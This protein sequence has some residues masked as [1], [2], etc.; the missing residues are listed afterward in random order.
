MGVIDVLKKLVRFVV[1]VRR[2]FIATAGHQGG[3]PVSTGIWRRGKRAV[4][5]N[6]LKRGNL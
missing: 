1:L 6:H 4:G 2:S 5:P 3:V